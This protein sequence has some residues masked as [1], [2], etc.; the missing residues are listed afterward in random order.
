MVVVI[1][2]IMKIIMIMIMIIIVMVLI[3]FRLS[4]Y[5]VICPTA[6][7]VK[8]IR[9]NIE[10]MSQLLLKMHSSAVLIAI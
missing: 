9:V 7:L 3:N 2:M 6:V 8:C 5:V 10:M 1:I 4:E